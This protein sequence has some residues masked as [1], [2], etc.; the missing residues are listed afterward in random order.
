MAV[1]AEFLQEKVTDPPRQQRLRA[2]FDRLA[3]DYPQL[4]GKIDWCQPLYTDHGTFIIVFKPTK[5]YLTVS[6]E[7]AA[8]TKFAVAIEEAGYTQIA[9]P[10]RSSWQQLISYLLLATIITF[11]R[12]D[13]QG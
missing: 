6:P 8:M 12:A 10:F 2:I 1:F 9:N 11:N 3:K 13:K 7:V 4:V 5:N